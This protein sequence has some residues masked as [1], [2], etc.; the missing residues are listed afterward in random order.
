MAGKSP[1]STALASRLAHRRIGKKA[2]DRQHD[3]AR[4]G[5]AAP[6]ILMPG[7]DRQGSLVPRLRLE[8]SAHDLVAGA[9]R[10]LRPDPPERFVARQFGQLV[11]I[12]GEILGQRRRCR[13][14]AGIVRSAA[15]D[16]RQ[17][18]DGEHGSSH[19][20]CSGPDEHPL[21]FRRVPANCKGVAVTRS[22][23]AIRM[24]PAGRNAK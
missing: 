20:D 6:L 23:V 11:A 2:P 3:R 4:H 21:N 14:G 13:V 16:H 5:P 24:R 22:E 7:D 17:E 8:H 18:Q 10:L 1:V 9:L 12:D 15:P 19:Q